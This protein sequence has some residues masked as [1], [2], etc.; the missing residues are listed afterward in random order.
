MSTPDVHLE[1]AASPPTISYWKRLA[2][3]RIPIS[4]VVIFGFGLLVAIAVGTVLAVGT[5]GSARNTSAHR[6]AIPRLRGLSLNES[7]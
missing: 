6:G 4:A 7:N 5:I 1:A 3:R 2:A